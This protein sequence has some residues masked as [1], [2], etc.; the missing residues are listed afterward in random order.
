MSRYR[1]NTK[2]KD[3][4]F[5]SRCGASLGIDFRDVLKPKFDGFGI[6]VCV[7]SSFF[8]SFSL[9]PPIPSRGLL[10]AYSFP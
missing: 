6:S 5:C 4:M 3:Q 9:I 8:F 10:L 1:F 2:L 7:F